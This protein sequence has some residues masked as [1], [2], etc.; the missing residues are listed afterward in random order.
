MRNEIFGRCLYLF[1]NTLFAKWTPLYFRLGCT[2]TLQV[3]VT[4]DDLSVCVDVLPSAFRGYS[5]LMRVLGYRLAHLY[6]RLPV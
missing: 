1:V 4:I 2:S 6:A 5:Q 3:C